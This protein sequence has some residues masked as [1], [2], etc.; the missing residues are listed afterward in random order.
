MDDQQSNQSGF[1]GTFSGA[2]TQSNPFTADLKGEFSSNFGTNTNAV[3][4]I[5]K[6]GGFASQRPTKLI[7]GGILLVAIAVGLGIYFLK[8]SSANK[9]ALPFEADTTELADDSLSASDLADVPS[10][11]TDIGVPTAETGEVSEVISDMPFE[12]AVETQQQVQPV[13]ES[14]SGSGAIGMLSPADSQVWEYDESKGGAPFEWDGGGSIV[15]SR[16]SSMRPEYIRARAPSG[17]YTLKNP[18]PGTWYWQVESA[19]GR[20]EVRRFTVSA[21]P[22]SSI[23]VSQPAANGALAGEGGV[24]AWQGQGK[25]AFYRVEFSNGSFANP[26]YRFATSGSSVQVSGVAPGAYQMRIGAFS[27]A[28]GRWEYTTPQSITVQ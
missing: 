8:D 2:N 19:D 1:G 6:D 11:D 7:I 5:F 22:R 14:F 3:S 13:A 18:Y 28:A 16:S 23:A 26:Q 27:E 10:V 4:Q 15:I 9:E 25:V 17:R 24:V 12:S 20:S 21:P